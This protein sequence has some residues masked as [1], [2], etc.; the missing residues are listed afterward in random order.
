MISHNDAPRKRHQ[1]R[2][3]RRERAHSALLLPAAHGSSRT[4]DFQAAHHTN[5]NS[6]NKPRAGET[7]PRPAC[8][9]THCLLMQQAVVTSR[10]LPVRAVAEV[11]AVTVAQG[12]F[13]AGG[14]PAGARPGAVTHFGKAV[15]PYIHE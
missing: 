12:K 7:A 1:A 4:G 5:T 6:G 9:Q 11:E 3:S 14:A 2:Q 10:Q 13:L 15:F 8:T